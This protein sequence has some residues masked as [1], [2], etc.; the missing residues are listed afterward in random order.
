MQRLISLLRTWVCGRG[1]PLA[2]GLVWVNRDFDFKTT[3]LSATVEQTIDLLRKVESQSRSFLA[4]LLQS[5]SS[6]KREGRGGFR[7]LPP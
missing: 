3:L 4:G 1:L 7:G 5:V 2:P 6:Q